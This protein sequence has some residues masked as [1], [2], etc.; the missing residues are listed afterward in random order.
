MNFLAHAVLTPPGRPGMLVGNLTADFIKGRARH[1]L[2][3]EIQAGIALHREIDA[4]TDT[5]PVVTACG[6][7]LD[8]R[9]GRY[10]TVLVDIFF[11]YCLASQWERY[12]GAERSGF[13][14]QTYR[15][16]ME[17]RA[18]LPERAQVAV[19]Y[20]AAD[21]WLGSYATVE[22]IRR[23]LERLTRRLRHGIDLAPAADDLAQHQ[24]AFGEAFGQFFPVLRRYAQTRREWGG[25]PQ[26]EGRR[27]FSDNRST[28][29]PF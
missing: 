22:G 15:C 11:D 5:H 21:D 14:R 6:A 20:M 23:S 8:E 16:L 2:P 9:W 1:A 29:E 18:V 3:E 10:A 27:S 17:Q 26:E 13:I 24:E 19:A 25:Q 7:W 28:R 12:A 4:F